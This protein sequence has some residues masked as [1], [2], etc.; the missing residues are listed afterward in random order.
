MGNPAAPRW[1]DFLELTKPRIVALV[2]VTVG[3]AFYLGASGGL[4]WGLLA[5]T[6]FG[7]ALVA[8]GTNGLNQVIEGKV[9]A[10]MRRTRQ[11]PIPAGRLAVFP[12]AVFA[13]A[14]GAGGVAWLAALV[15]PVAGLLAGLTLFSYA[16][17]YTPLKRRTTLATLVGAV[18]GALPVVG[19][20]V[21]ARGGLQLEAWVLFAILFLWQ[22]P[23]FLALAWIYRE[24]YAAA[25]MRMLSVGDPDGRATFR[26]AGL[27]SLALLSVA[28]LPAVIGMTGAT[29]F[30][31]A[32]LLTAWLGWAALSAA[33]QPSSSRARRLFQV[34]VAYLPALLILMM[35]D[36]RP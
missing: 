5:H 23:H 22:L 8:A 3:A 20:W 36:K 35:L 27:A 28:V 12:A 25:G 16:F 15:N 7:T 2:L 31:G 18:P 26:Q 17:V 21:A 24:D 1:S 33:L 9:D 10:L 13:S 32:L 34:S 19:G 14:L 11:R 6:L 30:W 4:P 29:Y